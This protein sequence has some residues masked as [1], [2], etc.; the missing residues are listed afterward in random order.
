MPDNGNRAETDAMTSSQVR[1]CKV[2]GN[3]SGNKTHLA[4]E[5]MFGLRNEFEYLECGCCGCVQLVAPPEDMAKYYPKDY[6]SYQHHGWLMNAIRRRWSAYAC[7]A[8]SL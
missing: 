2:C 3:A 7:G 8:K 6:Y 1:V 5:M 4:R